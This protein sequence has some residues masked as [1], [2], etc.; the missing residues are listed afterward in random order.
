M[1]ELILEIAGPEDFVKTA[2]MDFWAT[3]KEKACLDEQT[4]DLLGLRGRVKNDYEA[5]DKWENYVHNI[6]NLNQEVVIGITGKYTSLRDSYASIIKAL[7]HTGTHLGVKVKL[8]WIDTTDLV[9]ENVSEVLEGVSGIIVPGAFGSR[10][11]EGKI[12]C[13]K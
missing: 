3:D 2:S 10:G 13:I 11:A 8:K 7:E 1:T 6:L 9:E 5:R 4:I 12:N